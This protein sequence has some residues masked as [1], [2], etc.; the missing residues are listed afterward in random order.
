M[1]IKETLKKVGKGL[2][3]TK[4]AFAF[5]TFY[6]NVIKKDFKNYEAL[7]KQSDVMFILLTPVAITILTT[8]LFD[9]L[10]GST[11]LGAS[12]IIAMIIATILN[13]LYFNKVDLEIKRINREKREQERK[14]FMDNLERK[15][16]E[17]EEARKQ[18]ELYERMY[19]TFFESGG[20]SNWGNDWDS[21][22]EPKVKIDQN[23]I[24]AMN[25]MGLK[26]GFTKSELKSTYRSLSKIYH[27]DMPMGSEVNFKR[28]N[29]AY[30]YIL[31]RI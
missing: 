25:L 14:K 15:L 28:L 17:E 7:T 9:I 29:K 30:E 21:V 18:E 24:N 26:D 10:F 2:N 3:K 1:K 4:P 13:I 12:I 6:H 8:I 16:K 5:F 22:Q 11:L 27:P 23:M 19:K 31:E 20:Y